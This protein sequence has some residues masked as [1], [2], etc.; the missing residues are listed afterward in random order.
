MIAINFIDRIIKNILEN[1]HLVPYSIKCICR[2]ISEL[3]S[4]KFPTI[5][6]PDKSVFIAKFFFGK[7]LIPILLNPGVE[8]FINNFISQNSLYNLQIIAKILNK[9][10]SGTFYTDNDIEFNYTPFNWYFLHNINDLYTI[11]KK[12]TKVLFPSFIENFVNNK[13]PPD[14]EYDYFKENPDEVVNFRSIL[15][16]MDQVT[17]L[18]ETMDKNKADFFV[19]EEKNKKIRSTRITIQKLTNEINQG[20]IKNIIDSEKLINKE[21]E[22]KIAKGKD[23]KKQETEEKVEVKQHYFLVTRLD[24]NESYTKLLN[25]SKKPNFKIEEM[26]E[27]KNDEDMVKNNIIRVKNFFF[28]LLFNYHKLVKTDFDEGTTENTK[29]ILEELNL[30]MKSSNFV[31]DGTIPFEWLVKSIL[32]YL[33]KLPDYLTKNDCEELYNEMERDINKS[34]K[35]YDF[36]ALSVIMGKLNFAYRSLLYYMSK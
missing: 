1:F 14:Y 25:I 19:G 11:F 34:I 12:T 32:E 15:Y 24:S 28:S 6:F 2:I 35:E 29:T 3:V 22:K 8:A 10:I 13:L 30:F 5:S 26:K 20:I 16:N 23:K 17:A 4:K 7:L 18:I 27:T 33:K 21:K 31:M 9:Y 36:E